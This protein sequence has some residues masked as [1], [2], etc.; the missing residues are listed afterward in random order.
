[1]LV[2]HQQSL[3][4]ILYL[5]RGASE[6]L[7]TTNMR[8]SCRGRSP[9]RVAKYLSIQ[10]LGKRQLWDGETA[11]LRKPAGFLAKSTSKSSL[12]LLTAPSFQNMIKYSKYSI[13]RQEDQ[14][15]QAPPF[16]RILAESSCGFF[17]FWFLD[18]P[19]TIR[20][21]KPTS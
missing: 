20:E 6:L 18:P 7:P 2:G 13:S 17:L 19:V 9:R 1:M 15:A 12:S 5:L 10:P 16:Q 21:E 3:Q 8:G 11:L 4:Q 14:I